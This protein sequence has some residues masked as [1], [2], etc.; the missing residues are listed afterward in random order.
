MRLNDENAGIGFMESAE[1]EAKNRPRKKTEAQ[2]I[3]RP[4]RA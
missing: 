3:R 1:T 2:R 4:D